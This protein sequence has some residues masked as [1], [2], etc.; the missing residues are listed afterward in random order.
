MSPDF[1]INNYHEF[2]LEKF[3]KFKKFSLHR[4]KGRPLDHG[5]NGRVRFDQSISPIHKCK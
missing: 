3:I 5:D 2:F 4:L 1:K